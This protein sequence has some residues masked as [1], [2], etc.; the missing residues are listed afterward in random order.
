VKDIHFGCFLFIDLD[1]DSWNNIENSDKINPMDFKET[2]AEL[3]KEIDKELGYQFNIAIKGVR[4]KDALM[5]EALAQ[6]KNITLAGGKRIR[7]ALLCQA[8][9]GVGGKER[10]KIIK[11]ATA[12]ELVHMLLLVHDDI[13]DK[14][15]LRHGEKTLHTFFSEKKQKNLPADEVKHFGNSI[16]MITG[17]ML[18]AMAN[19]LIL[20]SKFNDAVIIQSLSQVQ[21][22]IET[23][24]AGQSQDV[25]IAHKKNATEKEILNMYKNKTARY[26]LEGPLYVGAML[27]GRNDRK[28]LQCL[29][30]YAV[31]VGIA[32]QIQ[33]DI[34]GIFGIKQKT[35]KLAVSDIEEGKRSIIVTKA[36]SRANLRQKKQLDSIL[37]KKNLSN[38]EIRTFQDILKS[39]GA[40]EYSKKMA[41]AYLVKGKREIKKIAFLPDTKRFLMGLTE[42][43]ED[44]ET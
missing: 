1:F 32:F 36:F 44:R 19:N 41:A 21:S 12:I 31:P 25:W 29:S 2:L 9:F 33:D 7:G 8:Y 10:K 13:M 43:L 23:T 34:L 16:A 22:I 28:F 26:T 15:W 27:A 14:G 3:K 17:D 20:E 30:R 35:G 11:A 24:I 42:Y 4:K 6:A 39:T 38:K 18:Y 37:G 5:A 40:L